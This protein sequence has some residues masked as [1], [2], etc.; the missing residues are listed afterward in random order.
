MSEPSFSIRIF[1]KPPRHLHDIL[2]Y[3]SIGENA[4]EA[5]NIIVASEASDEQTTSEASGSCGRRIKAAGLAFCSCVIMLGNEPPK[6]KRRASDLADLDL[7][8][9][10]EA[11][12]SRFGEVVILFPLKG[13]LK[14]S[15]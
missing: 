9:A 2:V 11:K 14:R 6:L 15:F 4:L 8:E 1:A 7:G 13:I 10:T 12:R 5:K 3:Q